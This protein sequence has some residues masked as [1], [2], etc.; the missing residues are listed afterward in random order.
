MMV[1]CTECDKW[2]LVYAKKKL[3]NLQKENLKAI[4]GDIDYTCG[5]M[6]GKL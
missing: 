4:M 2:R 6:M 5:M 1:Q 3:N